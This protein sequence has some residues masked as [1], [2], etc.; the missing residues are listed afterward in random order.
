[1]FASRCVSQSGAPNKFQ[2]CHLDKT[3][4]DKTSQHP[5][6]SNRKRF[7]DLAAG[8]SRSLATV[9][10][11]LWRSTD[12]LTLSFKK[13]LSVQFGS[14]W[15]LSLWRFWMAAEV[16]NLERT[17][18]ITG[19]KDDFHG[20]GRKLKG[21]PKDY[22]E[23]I[24]VQSQVNEPKELPNTGHFCVLLRQSARIQCKLPPPPQH[25]LV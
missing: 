24:D 16:I 7:N 9:Y 19:D 6:L 20:S 5:F 14:I 10:A 21:Q 23:H 12:P 3:N 22:I 4:M 13:C 18:V 17:I 11:I 1:M 2:N 25:A 8:P 15:V